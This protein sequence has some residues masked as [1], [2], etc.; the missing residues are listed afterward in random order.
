MRKG[1]CIIC[2]VLLLSLMSCGKGSV[3]NES[4]KSQVSSVETT[5]MQGEEELQ[6]V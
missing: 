3:S 1:L 2:G 5:Q 4:D 6:G